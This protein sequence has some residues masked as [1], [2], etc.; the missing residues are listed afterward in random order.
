MNRQDR[1]GELLA[2]VSLLGQAQTRL[3]AL[4][5]G[6]PSGIPNELKHTLDE[7]RCYNA[8]ITGEGLELLETV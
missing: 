8:V 7:P 3:D 5:V 4:S 1:A 6:D 2:I